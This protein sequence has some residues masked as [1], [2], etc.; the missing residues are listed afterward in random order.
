MNTYEYDIGIIGGG[1]AGITLARSLANTRIHVCVIEAGG[2]TADPAVQ[3][4]YQGDSTGIPYSTVATRLRFFGGSS[5][6][7]SASACRLLVAVT[8]R[9]SRAANS[10][11]WLCRAAPGKAGSGSVTA[12]SPSNSVSLSLA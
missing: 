6:E 3:S 8:C 1:A 10:C 11:S 5:A 2:L 7:A 9:A 4:L 12:S